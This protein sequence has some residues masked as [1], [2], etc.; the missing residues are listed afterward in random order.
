MEYVCDGT[1]QCPLFEDEEYCDKES[2]PNNCHCLGASYNCSNANL[3]VI[4]HQYQSLRKFIGSHNEI[5]ISH[6][7]V[8]LLPYLMWLDLS[9]N[10]IYNLKAHN[11]ENLQNLQHLDLGH[12]KIR[13]VDSKTFNELHILM[14]LI[15]EGNQ[16]QKLDNFAFDGLIALTSLV[17]KNQSMQ[18]ISLLAFQSLKGTIKLDLSSNCL[19]DLYPEIFQGMISLKYLDTSGNFISHVQASVLLD[20]MREIVADTKA[21]CCIARNL[22]ICVVKAYDNE[23]LH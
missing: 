20:N 19:T 8:P 21:V 9:N 17:L 2:C 5:E 22:D 12:N 14:V 16:I 3:K 23:A 10:K 15:L 7:S 6:I 18:H 1:P 13:S 11:F 4:P